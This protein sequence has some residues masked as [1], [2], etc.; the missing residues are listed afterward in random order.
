M[1]IGEQNGEMQICIEESPHTLAENQP[2]EMSMARGLETDVRLDRPTTKTSAR[3]QAGFEMLD[4][5][6]LTDTI[7]DQ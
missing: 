4:T 1:P 2:A 3:S 7:E 5:D 6:N